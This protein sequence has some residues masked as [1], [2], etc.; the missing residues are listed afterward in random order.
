[1]RTSF[2]TPTT[3]GLLIDWEHGNVLRADDQATVTKKFAGVHPYIQR[4]R[5]SGEV[6]VGKGPTAAR[7]VVTREDDFML[8]L[9]K[10]EDQ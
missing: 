2:A 10:V 9:Q 4:D 3:G 5:T 7:Y 1:M 6:I 8:E